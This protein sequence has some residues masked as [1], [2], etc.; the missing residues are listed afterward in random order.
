MSCQKCKHEFCWVCSE[1]YP[2]YKHE[3]DMFH[4]YLK[5]SV[6]RTIFCGLFAFLVVKMLHMSNP[7]FSF[8][9][10]QRVFDALVEG[11]SIFTSY[12]ILVTFLAWITIHLMLLMLALIGIWLGLKLRRFLKFLGLP[13]RLYIYSLIYSCVA[14]LG[15]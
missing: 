11:Q 13:S 3:G 2:S 14:F 10:T 15:I 8:K 12:H 1:P 5:K 4:H 9:N 7:V 6:I